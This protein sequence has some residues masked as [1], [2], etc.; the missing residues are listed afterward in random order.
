MY[1][2]QCGLRVSG[3]ID[4]VDTSCSDVSN[5]DVQ[6]VWRDVVQQL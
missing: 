5:W 3:W 4:V 2:L 1:G 6:F